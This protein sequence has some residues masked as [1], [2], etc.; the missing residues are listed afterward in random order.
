MFNE[1]T[2]STGQETGW[3]TEPVGHYGK[4]KNFPLYHE[5]NRNTYSF[6]TQLSDSECGANLKK[7]TFFNI[8]KM[9][10]YRTSSAMNPIR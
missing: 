7:L 1:S 9:M 8:K 3:A 2:I 4:K 5:S 6:S 10:L